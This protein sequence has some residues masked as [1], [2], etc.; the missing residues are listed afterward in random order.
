MIARAILTLTLTLSTICAADDDAE[1]RKTMVM[2]IRAGVGATSSEIGKETLNKQVMHAMATVPRH[3]FVPSHLREYAYLNRPLP[4][5]YGQTISQPYIV[6]LM[7]DIVDVNSDD[8]VL[9]IGTGS[10]YQ[11]AVLAELVKHVYTIE[12]IKDLGAQ[13]SDRLKRLG[14]NKVTTRIGDGYYGW[15]QYAPFDAIVVTAAAGQIPPPLIEQ[16]KLG[17]KMVIPVGTGFATQYLVLVKKDPDGKVST[18]ELLPVR[19]VPLTGGH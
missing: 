5:G 13:A 2:E 4:I 15:E 7:T 18:K 12:I 1:A 3:E 8:V 19:F 9:E 10:G 16:L 11:A 14:Y 17:G 6:A